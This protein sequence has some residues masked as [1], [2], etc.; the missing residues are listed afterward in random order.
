VSVAWIVASA[1]RIAARV[2]RGERVAHLSRWEEVMD[3][4]D[5]RGGQATWGDVSWRGFH[6]IYRAR[7]WCLMALCTVWIESGDGGVG[8]RYT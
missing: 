4:G 2:D 7:S 5:V 8:G 3:L 6:L 1:P